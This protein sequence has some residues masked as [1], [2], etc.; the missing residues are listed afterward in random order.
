MTQSEIELE[1]CELQEIL[2]GEHLDLEGFLIQGT[3]GGVESLPQEELN[4]IQ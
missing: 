2:E 1:E 4:R 3:T